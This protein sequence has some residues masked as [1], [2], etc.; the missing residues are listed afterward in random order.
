MILDKIGS[1]IVKLIEGLLYLLGYRYKITLGRHK[2]YID[3][4]KPKK[5]AK[6]DRIYDDGHYVNGN[7]YLKGGA[8]PVKVGKGLTDGKFKVIPSGK[9]MKF[10]EMKVL[11]DIARLSEG[12][13][14][15]KGWKLVVLMIAINT[16]IS[17]FL[18]ILLLGGF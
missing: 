14:E 16:T 11:N 4:C 2:I 18:L 6:D 8:N 17:A 12:D 7:L 13:M 3:F 9:Y 10:M 5:M 1:G 15:I